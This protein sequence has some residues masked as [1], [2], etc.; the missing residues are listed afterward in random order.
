MDKAAVIEDISE[1]F[2]FWSRS[3]SHIAVL[4]AEDGTVLEPA[5]GCSEYEICRSLYPAAPEI[6]PLSLSIRLYGI[7]I[8]D[9]TAVYECN[10]VAVDSYRTCLAYFLA[11]TCSIF[12]GQVLCKEIRSIKKDGRS[13]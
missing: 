4:L 9:K 12:Y 1:F 13:R 6:L 7:L 11:F 5:C 3:C 10:A 2:P 8:G